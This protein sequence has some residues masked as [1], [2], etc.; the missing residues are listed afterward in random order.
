MAALRLDIERSLLAVGFGA[1]CL[2]FGVVAGLDPRL[3]IGGA[4]ALGF[5][6]LAIA[7]LTAGLIVFA[8]LAYFALTPGAVGSF[9]SAQAASLVLALS[10][11]A[12]IA[13]RATP[14]DHFWSRHPAITWLALALLAWVAL[15]S[16]WAESAGDTSGGA[17]QVRTGRAPVRDRVRGRAHPRTG[18][19]PARRPGRGRHG[20]S[21]LRDRRLPEPVE[22]GGKPHAR[23]PISI[24]SAARSP[25]RT[26]SPRCSWWPSSWRWR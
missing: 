17:A 19:G 7:D 1:L 5:F 13:T 11:L 23:P 2:A 21:R 18:Q 26:C 4:L 12:R 3:A 25:T 14:S 24:A 16:L 15:S 22:P 20:G 10:W 9:V 6:A 8:L